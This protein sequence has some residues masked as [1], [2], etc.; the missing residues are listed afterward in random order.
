MT[1]ITNTPATA[2]VSISAVGKV[3]ASKGSNATPNLVG[4]LDAIVEQRKAWEQ[5]AYKTS[6]DQLYTMLGRCLDIYVQLK[7][8]EDYKVKQRQALNDRLKAAGLPYKETTP[9]ATKVVRYVFGTDRRRSYTYAR[10]IVSAH[11]HGIDSVKFPT[12]VRNAGGIEEVKR[13][14]KSGL[15]PKDIRNRQR[16]AA[17]KYFYGSK[18]LASFASVKEVKPSAES[19]SRFA[20]ALIR[21]EDDGTAAVVYGS[22]NATVVNLLLARAGKEVE[23][24][25]AEEG[26]QSANRKRKTTRAAA[27]SKAA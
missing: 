6:N 1:T 27:V 20:Y 14:A 7:G 21:T 24:K 15:S 25:Q 13:K 16:D 26:K 4:E 22:N 2:T 5:G 12:W 23:S 11:E 10:T 18:P 9:L 19:T 3:K 8:R 17:E